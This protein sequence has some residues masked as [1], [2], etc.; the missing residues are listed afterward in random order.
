[1]ASSML[2]IGVSGARAARAALDVTAQNIA[3][4]N[5]E[6]Y[7]RRGVTLTELS[8][9]NGT[10]RIADMS[11][12]GV[13]VSGVNRLA[14]A[15]R[16]AELRRTTSDAARAGAELGGLQNVESALEQSN[17]F[18]GIVEFE[19]A[20]Q[21]LET[22]PVDPS[23]R[24]A[25]LGAADNLANGFNLAAS[26]LQA[27]GDTQRFEA[28]AEVGNANLYA[29]ELAR[30]NMRLLRVGDGT[31]DRA[32]LLDQRD[33][34]LEKLSGIADVATSFDDH[35]RVAVTLGG[36]ALVTGDQAG[37]LT[38]GINPDG[39][40]AF[41]VDGAAV[42]PAGGTLAGRGLVLE[43]VARQRS[44]LDLLATDLMAALNSVQ[45]GGVARD[46]SPGQPLFAGSGAA[47]IALALTEGSQLATAPAGVGADSRDGS[48]LA[49]LRDALATGKTAERMN[50]LLFD[51]S[52]KVAGRKITSEALD[53]IA[54]A[55]RTAFLDQA[56]VDLEQEAAN[57]VRFQQAFQAS[58]RVMQVA[59]DIFDTILGI[60]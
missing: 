52:N 58:G 6:G 16:L 7:I 3:N 45:Q 20:L 42:T 24:A 14:D 11:F 13:R 54:G 17:L 34:L 29:T 10:G 53:A 44:A 39:T 12:S 32:T 30:V 49:A 47:D 28:E 23:L 26:S 37:T 48:N 25:A 55:A 4:A 33:G 18:A 8:A 50:G 21:R 59:G 51:L 40:L 35:G 38:L 15:F 36:Q 46:G 57:L 9:A 5:S 22:D 19:G 1:M 43:E 31:A 41:A 27:V 60:R 56:G 2:Q